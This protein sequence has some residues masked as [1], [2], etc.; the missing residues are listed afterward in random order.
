[1]SQPERMNWE[2]GFPELIGHP[3]RYVECRADVALHVADNVTA[4]GGPGVVVGLRLPDRRMALTGV[5]LLGLLDDLLD[6]AR[7]CGLYPVIG[8]RRPLEPPDRT[9]S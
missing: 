7:L 3:E 6:G 9:S 4:V 5:D 8:L 2:L 1:M